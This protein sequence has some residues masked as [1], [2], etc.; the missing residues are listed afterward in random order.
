MHFARKVVQSA[1]MLIARESKDV[2]NVP[3][4]QLL[5]S[6]VELW[7][8][9]NVPPCLPLPAAEVSGDRTI[10]DLFSQLDY[11]DMW[12]DA[13]VCAAVRYVRGSK[14]LRIPPDLRHILP[15]AL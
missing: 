3:Y 12:P 5:S 9:L 13:G 8:S 1:P 14:A 7:G 4:L 6:F 15:D 10:E 11:E 2:V